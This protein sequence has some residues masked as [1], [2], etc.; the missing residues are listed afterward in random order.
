MTRVEIIAHEALEGPLLGALAPVPGDAHDPEGR[1]GRPF[2]LVRQAAGRGMSGSA[3]GDDV[4]PETNIKIVLFLEN[5]EEQAVRDAIRIIRRSYPKLGLAV[6]ALSGYDEWY[7]G[8][9]GDA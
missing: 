6:F 7:D 2:T 5:S 4:W 8:A 3:F 1:S 9:E